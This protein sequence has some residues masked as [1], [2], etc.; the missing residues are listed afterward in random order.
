VSDYTSPSGARFDPLRTL[1]RAD[2]G[3]NTDDGVIRL[4][5]KTH[6][7]DTHHRGTDVYLADDG[8]RTSAYA[9]L[10]DYIAVWDATHRDPGLPLFITTTGVYVTRTII[11]NALKAAA[12]HHGIDPTY[13]SS[14][15]IRIAAAQALADTGMPDYMIQAAGRWASCAFQTYTRHSVRRVHAVGGV[16]NLHHGHHRAASPRPTPRAASPPARLSTT[17]GRPRHPAPPSTSA[18]L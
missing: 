18:R 3:F 7:T 12:A 14:H 16:L 6:K 5:L 1:T 15:S 9:L 10:T 13:I 4:H 8:T 11:S 2:I 17:T